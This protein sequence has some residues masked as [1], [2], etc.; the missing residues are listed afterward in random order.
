MKEYIHPKVVVITGASAGVGRAAAKRFARENHKIALLARGEKG[1]EAA[2]EEVESLGGA[3]ITIKCD[4]S[5]Y[6]Q[7]DRAA[8]EVEEKFGPIDIWI[9]NAMVT[10]FAPFMEIEPKDYKRVTDVTYLGQVNGTHAALKRMKP[11]DRGTIIHV[12]SAL[13]YRGIPLQTAYCGAK[14]AIQGFTESLRSELLH[15][16]SSV[17]IAMVQMPA[18]NTPQFDWCKTTFDKKPQPVPPIYQPEVAADAIYYAA[19][20]KKSEMYVGMSTAIIVNGN[21]FFPRYGDKYLAKNGVNSQLTNQDIDKDRPNNLYEPVEGD[22][23]AHGDFDNISK[24]D[25]WQLKIDKNKSFIGA[26]AAGFAAV[27]VLGTF[28]KRLF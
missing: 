8:S 9:N 28:I 2:K 27:T 17:H 13:A 5:D 23:G 16:G 1:L 6:E 24:G 15:E 14:H 20:N 10:V 18:L 12:G 21:K 3:A 7:V 4:V 25:S 26:A 19:F 22:F 11:R